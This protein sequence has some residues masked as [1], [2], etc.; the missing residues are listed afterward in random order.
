MFKSIC[1]LYFVDRLC[2]AQ[3]DKILVSIFLIAILSFVSGI[4]IFCMCWYNYPNLRTEISNALRTMINSSNFWN[5]KMSPISKI[6]LVLMSSWEYFIYDSWSN[7]M[8]YFIHFS[9]KGSKISIVKRE[10]L[11]LVI[12]QKR[13]FCHYILN[14]DIF[15]F[16]CYFFVRLWHIQTN[17]Q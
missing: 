8:I 2:I 13:I 1:G 11:F 3:M 15:Y 12:P 16:F 7:A 4:W 10:E 9:S 5:I 14:E 17:W 6:I